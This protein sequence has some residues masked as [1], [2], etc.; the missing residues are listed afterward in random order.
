MLLLDYIICLGFL[1]VFFVL[2]GYILYMGGQNIRN[3]CDYNAAQ[4][5]T[6]TNYDLNAKTI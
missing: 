4:Y 2:P 1:S 6:I 3:I 5:N